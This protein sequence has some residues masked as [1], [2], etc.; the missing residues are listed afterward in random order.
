MYVYDC[1]RKLSGTYRSHIFNENYGSM[2]IKQCILQIIPC[3]ST[4]NTGSA[5]EINC[6]QFGNE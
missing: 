4:E 3:I 6:V 1:F 2:N 5:I